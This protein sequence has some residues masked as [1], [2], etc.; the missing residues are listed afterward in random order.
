M[1][2]LISAKKLH[3]TINDKALII[4]DASYLLPGTKE[5]KKL[6]CLP[7]SHFWDIDK[8]A[9]HSTN[10]PHMMPSAENFSKMRADFGIA[11]NSHIIVY[12]LYGIFLAAVRIWWMFKSFGHND[13]QI[14]DGGLPNWKNKGYKIKSAYAPSLPPA[15]IFKAKDPKNEI[16]DANEILNLNDRSHL[17]DARDAD[18]FL[19]QIA[20]LRPECRRGHIPQSK[21]LF[22]GDFID[23]QTGCLKPKTELKSIL[24]NANITPDKNIISSCGSG[25]TACILALARAECNHTGKTQI[26]DGSWT[27]WGANQNLPIAN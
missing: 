24:T 8:Y 2:N 14:L 4:L 21:N 26:Y 11:E 6:E 12:D 7:K 27:E 23:P 20:E 19:G 1:K 18:R 15:K 17:Y 3:E 25:V 16:I 13:I 22:F 9:D 5:P 10:L